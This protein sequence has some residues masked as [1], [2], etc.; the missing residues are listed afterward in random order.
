MPMAFIG[1]E[2]AM[3]RDYKAEYRRRIARGSAAGLSRSQAR[4]HARTG[5]TPIKQAPARDTARLR[6]GVKAFLKHGS[7]TTA[8]KDAGISAERLRREVYERRIAQRKGR[9][10]QPLV[11]EIG[12]ISRGRERVIKTD[13]DAASEVGRYRN[14]VA[15]FLFTQDE[16]LLAPFVGVSITDLSGKSH[17]FETDPNVLYELSLMGDSTFEQ[18]YRLISPT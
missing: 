11:R 7:V 8:A 12:I 2:Q 10:V 6:R 9:R 14:A 13:F 16:S 4:G 5:E 1:A 3:A 17:P 18:I 15:K